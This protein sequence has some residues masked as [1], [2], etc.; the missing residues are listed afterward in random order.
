MKNLKKYL[1]LLSV[2]GLSLFC[3]SCTESVEYSEADKV[4]GQEVYFPNTI[5]A[6]VDLDREKTSHI[7]QLMRG[8]TEGALKLNLNVEVSGKENL[9][10][11][12]RITFPSSVEFADGSNTADIV[13][14]YA[15]SDKDYDKFIDVEMSLTEDAEVTPF[16][17]STISFKIGVP[18]PWGPVIKEGEESNGK[19]TMGTYMDDV[20]T[21]IFTGIE[22][23][24]YSV[25]IQQNAIDKTMFR[26]VEPYGKEY[27]YH[28]DLVSSG[29][30]YDDSKKHYLTFSIKEPEKVVISGETGFTISNEGAIG[31]A[32]FRDSEGVYKN[33]ILTF[34]TKG[35]AFTLD[36]EVAGYAN[37]NG[38]FKI[39]MPGIELA[40]YSLDASF[41]GF[42]NANDGSV[43]GVIATVNKVGEDVKTIGFAIEK[44][45]YV[46]GEEKDDTVALINNIADNKYSTG[47]IE[48]PKNYI[49]PF[50]PEES[51]I[52]SLLAVTLDEDN[53]KNVSK[54]VFNATAES[55]IPTFKVNYNSYY[56]KVS[57]QNLVMYQSSLNNNRFK[58][59]GS[60]CYKDFVFESINTQDGVYLIPVNMVASDPS[61]VV[62]GELGVLQSNKYIFLLNFYVGEDLKM[63]ESQ[64]VFTITEAIDSSVKPVSTFRL[65]EVTLKKVSFANKALELISEK[66]IVPLK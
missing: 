48:Y 51:G 27:P 15:I 13:I 12:S 7:L 25:E 46:L 20:M 24:A 61:V 43:S 33:G 2:S 65:E 57:E 39:A 40:D 42:H 10:S 59:S 64:E 16:G 62:T 19:P 26:I 35:V 66:V 29:F 6:Q 47:D 55:W 28:E 30:P 22:P 17:K 38:A 50:V 63:E 5:P 54:V 49:I 4:K 44:G 14:D 36:G 3:S 41:G 32:T 31:I 9:S 37:K 1:F 21:C 23:E 56:F 45:N 8:K 34:P 58:I 60:K 11:G 53:V 18:A 52:Y